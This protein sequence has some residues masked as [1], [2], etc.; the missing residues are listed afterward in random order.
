M[1]NQQTLQELLAKPGTAARV[2]LAS[3]VLSPPQTTLAGHPAVRR[4]GSR[5]RV[6]HREPW[7]G[8][9]REDYAWRI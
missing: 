5:A 8:R 1:C 3:S 9:E 6:E 4:G 2:V 7:H